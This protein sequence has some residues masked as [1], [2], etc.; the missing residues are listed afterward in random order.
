MTKNILLT[1]LDVSRDDR[2]P[3]YY[4]AKSEFGFNYC[5]AMQSIEAGTKLILARVPVAEI[6]IIGEEKFPSLKLGTDMDV[7][8]SFKLKDAEYLANAYYE[9]H[10]SAFDLYR[11]RM[12]QFINEVST[13][14][15]SDTLVDEALRENLVKLI[16][17]FQ[18]SYSERETKRLNRFFDELSGNRDLYE[19][20]ITY[21]F[22]SLPDLRKN[23]A[24]VVKWVENYLYNELKPSAKLECLEVNENVSARYIP[25]V[26]LE[27]REF[28]VNSM[29]DTDPVVSGGE[30]EINLYVVLSNDSAI[31]GQLIL[32]MLDILI[33]TPGSNVCLKKIYKV[34]DPA[35]SLTVKIED[36]TALSKST[37]LV[38]AA[39]A[40]L[41][42]SKT[43]MLV[44]FWENSGVQDER[45]SKLIYAARHVDVGISMC[46]IPEVQ[47]GIDRLHEIF[48]DE[49]SWKEESEYGLLFGIIA[50]CIKAD[51]KPLLEG[52]G[53]IPFI[54][55]IKWT[56]KHQLY[57][58]VLTL[59]ESHAPA[60]IVRSGI[61]YYCDDENKAADV[62]KI[63]AHQRLALKP[64][65]Y[66]KM[67]D[68]EH[69]F[70]KT[71]DRSAVILNGS[72]GED[73]NKIYSYLRI[74]SIDN[75]TP[76]KI[77][78][79]TA[80]DDT[81]TVQ[82]VLY[83]YYH[84]GEVR[85]KISHADTRAMAE[86]RLIVYDN[87]ISSAMLLMRESIE[88]FINN[89]EEALEEVRYK[90]PNIVTITSEEVRN[91]SERLK[92]ENK[93]NHRNNERKE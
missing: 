67:E 30:D 90:N 35:G 19:K 63:L 55:L 85:N 83:A 43:D 76:E 9:T 29:L 65:E 58:Q 2:K 60:N 59:I 56:Y 81:I 5:E 14:E 50:E 61:F 20:L 48:R 47:E 73:R 8:K 6:L 15:D 88:F 27:K 86:C 75:E 22:T 78:G 45:I 36:S 25:A 42:Y 4:S 64:Y 23:T 74:L 31:D 69:Y 17:D 89:Y 38:S 57:Q 84:L 18:E 3:R 34:I 79:H 40:F 91:A 28:W 1:T 46:N 68:I 16:N 33:S 49:S 52:D 41:N 32:N 77:T 21:L 82:K 11:Y 13:E 87:E 10:H 80:C 71:Y 39:H 93:D 37:K 7:E 62:I 92:R 72:K 51:Y 53:T 70:I 12:A 54:E 24:Q 66:Y 44:N 26:M